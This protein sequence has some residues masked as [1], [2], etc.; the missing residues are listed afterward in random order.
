MSHKAIHTVLTKFS[1]Q[2]LESTYASYLP[3]LPDQNRGQQDA[4][5]NPADKG[6]HPLANVPPELFPEVL[7]TTA[8][9]FQIEL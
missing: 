6:P 4:F 7:M 3:P 1:T 2:D 9:I 8:D 5:A